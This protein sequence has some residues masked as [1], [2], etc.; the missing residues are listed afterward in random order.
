SQAGYNPYGLWDLSAYDTAYTLTQWLG[1]STGTTSGYANVDEI[2]SVPASAV[3]NCGSMNTFTGSGTTDWQN[4]VVPTLGDLAKIP[5]YDIYGNSTDSSDNGYQQST[6]VYNGTAYTNYPNNSPTNAVQLGIAIWNTVDNVGKTIRTQNAMNPIKILTI[7]YTGN[8]GTDVV[9][10]KRLANEADST[11]F[12][13]SP[14]QSQGQFW[15]VDNAN[16]LGPVFADVAAS[17]LRLAK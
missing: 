15:Q 9:L 1:Y 4:G 12:V 16:Q 7:G 11:S 13:A 5:Q 6:S 14:T 17:L 3:S 10:L 8:G 2:R